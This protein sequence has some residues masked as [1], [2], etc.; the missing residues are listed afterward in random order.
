MDLLDSPASQQRKEKRNIFGLKVKKKKKD[1]TDLVLA[2]KGAVDNEVETSSEASLLQ[3]GENPAA[4]PL[5]KR[6]IIPNTKR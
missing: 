1:S 3:E 2:N 5:I 4:Q 6:R